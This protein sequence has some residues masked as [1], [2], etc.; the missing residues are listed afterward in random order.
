MEK[1]IKRH[2]QTLLPG[3]ELAL[4]RQMLASRCG[5]LTKETKYK[6]YLISEYYVT[7]T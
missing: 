2:S 4:L 5:N 1:K 7:I 6:I 3:F